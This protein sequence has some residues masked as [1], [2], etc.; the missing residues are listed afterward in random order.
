MRVN[1]VSVTMKKG[2]TVPGPSTNPGEAKP[3][4][5]WRCGLPRETHTVPYGHG[6]RL[7]KVLAARRALSTSKYDSDAVLDETVRRLTYDL[8]IV[9]SG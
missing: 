9:C 4:S 7:S 1:E 6:F 3:P 2:T 8:G 5:R